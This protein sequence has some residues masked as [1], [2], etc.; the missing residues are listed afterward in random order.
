M[1]VR[2]KTIF[3]ASFIENRMDRRECLFTPSNGIHAVA[4]DI[5]SG[6]SGEITHESID[7]TLN[8]MLHKGGP[9]NLKL[10]GATQHGNGAD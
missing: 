10:P 4:V 7:D 2:L 8:E 1:L 3:L 6:S 5:E 9:L